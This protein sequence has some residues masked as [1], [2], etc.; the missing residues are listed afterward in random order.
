M[1]ETEERWSSFKDSVSDFF[2]IW[3]SEL[4]LVDT[5]QSGIERLSPPGTQKEA[6][7]GKNIVEFFPDIERTGRYQ[8]YLNVIKTGKPLFI[9]DTGPHPGYGQRHFMVKAFKLGDGMGHI[10]TDLT[11]H[12]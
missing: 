1:S 6:L 3:D 7:L 8:E 10:I 4:N 2:C 12:R 9:E 5:S 11:E